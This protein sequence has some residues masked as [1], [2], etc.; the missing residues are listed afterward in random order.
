MQQT[1]KSK[2]IVVIDAQWKLRENFLQSHG[3]I[4]LKTE[5]QGGTSWFELDTKDGLGQRLTPEGERSWGCG[6]ESGGAGLTWAMNDINSPISAFQVNRNELIYAD[7][8]EIKRLKNGQIDSLVQ[9]DLET[10]AFAGIWGSPKGQ[11]LYYVLRDREMPLSEQ[12]QILNKGGMFSPPNGHFK[13]FKLETGARNVRSWDLGPASLPHAIDVWNAQ[14]FHLSAYNGGLSR[15]DLKL[16]AVA[17]IK[18]PGILPLGLSP[19]SEMTLLAWGGMGT[20]FP[21]ITEVEFRTGEAVNICE[22]GELPGLSPDMQSLAFLSD[23]GLWLLRD[24]TATLMHRFLPFGHPGCHIEW[25]ECG[26]YL[27]VSIPNG[28]KADTLIREW[29]LALLIADTQEHEI[30]KFDVRPVA[31]HWKS[32]KTTPH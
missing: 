20:S 8:N 16:G 10:Q 28:I 27:T 21:G 4:V 14:V 1:I 2:S 30:V 32:C 29:P 6:P 15:I 12:I 26:R 9:F 7:H 19:L 24:G 13:L 5:P 22:F 25:C 17:S 31:Y 3:L 23:D 18:A 11:E